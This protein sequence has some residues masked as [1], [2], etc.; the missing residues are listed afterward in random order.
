MFA[1]SFV[2]WNFLRSAERNVLDVIALQR[3][4]CE[5]FNITCL[6]LSVLHPPWHGNLTY[7]FLQLE[8][9]RT[10]VPTWA[11]GAPTEKKKPKKEKSS[12]IGTNQCIPLFFL[13]VAAT[14]PK[15]HCNNGA[16]KCN[17]LEEDCR[18]C[19]DFEVSFDKCRFGGF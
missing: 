16:E 19:V 3:V 11:L 1:T 13:R 14:R 12:I 8:D 9:S 7:T 15:N 10:A 6:I 2:T 4:H 17:V 5:E 18:C